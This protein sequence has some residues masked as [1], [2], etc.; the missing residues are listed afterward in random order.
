MSRKGKRQKKH[1]D[2]KEDQKR[3]KVIWGSRYWFSARKGGGR[4]VYKGVVRVKE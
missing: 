4:R 2:G 1:L 3:K